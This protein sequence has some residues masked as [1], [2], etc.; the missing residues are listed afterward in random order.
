MRRSSKVRP[1]GGEARPAGE[2]A[3]GPGAAAPAAAPALPP[4]RLQAS[5]PFSPGGPAHGDAR[6]PAEAAGSGRGSLEW[7]RQGYEEGGCTHSA[8]LQ[9]ASSPRK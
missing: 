7:L 6:G 8:D 5:A 3:P 9:Y 1:S 4:L 2:Q